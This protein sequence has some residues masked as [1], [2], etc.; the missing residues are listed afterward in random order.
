MARIYQDAGSDGESEQAIRKALTLQPEAWEV[1][2][3]AGRT[4]YNQNCFAESVPFFERALIMVENDYS[5]WQMLASAYKVLGDPDGVLRAAAAMMSQSQK[6]L[7]D[8]P[9]HVAALATNACGCA[10]LG[11]RQR[12][13]ERIELALLLDPDNALS[14][15]NFACTS[16]AFLGDVELA[17]NLLE[18]VLARESAANIAKFAIRDPDL[19]E[20]RRN[21]RFQRI[22][23]NA[24]E[25]FGMVQAVPA[26]AT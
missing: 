9:G 25:R 21:S 24:T 4:F 26:P 18:P 2:R 3:E 6:V 15:Y 5:A 10:I 16:A 1:I 8:D 7:D 19:A 11:D 13:D 12:F 20:V 17:I 14:R 23:A 22:L